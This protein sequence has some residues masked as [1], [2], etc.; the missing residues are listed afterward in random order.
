MSAEDR[1]QQIIEATLDVVARHGVGGA[2]TSRIA[3]AAGISAA[4]L[5]KYF[6]SRDEL[7]MA[8]LDLLFD[9]IEAAVVKASDETNVLDRLRTI[10]RIHSNL[11]ISDQTTFIYPLFE[12][13]AS[14]RESGLREAQG[15][16]QL[17]VIQAL[18]AVVEEGKAQGSIKPDVDSEQV[19]WD[20]HAV[21]W[22]ED[23]S[24]L[25]GL[26][27]F[28]SAGRSSTILNNILNNIANRPEPAMS[29]DDLIKLKRLLA[30]CPLAGDQ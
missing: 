8:A 7:L 20:I 4:A 24:H 2:T 3:A 30:A 29:P 26:D 12:F 22:A 6:D 15:T 17:A 10:G 11:I 5:Y 9:R 19:A 25:M 14:S 13:L 1:K 27:Q 23:I 21:Y 28:V 16:R 18:A